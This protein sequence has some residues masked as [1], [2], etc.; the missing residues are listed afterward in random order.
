MKANNYHFDMSNEPVMSSLGLNEPS[1]PH[2]DFEPVSSPAR[3]TI[4]FQEL[5]EKEEALKTRSQKP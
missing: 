3:R 2:A 5:K 1:L 4:F